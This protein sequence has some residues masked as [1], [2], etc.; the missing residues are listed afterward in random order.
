MSASGLLT[1]GLGFGL[2]PGYILTRGL[3]PRPQPIILQ[4]FSNTR[5]IG[6]LTLLNPGTPPVGVAPL[7]YRTYIAGVDRSQY[8]RVGRS[9]GPG[10]AINLTTS[11]S[12]TCTFTVNGWS[13][14]TIPASVPVNSQYIPARRDAVQVRRATDGLLMF[15]GFVDTLATTRILGSPQSLQTVVTCVDIGSWLDRRFVAFSG[16]IFWINA[17]ADSLINYIVNTFLQNTGIT[18]VYSSNVNVALGDQLFNYITARE[19]L[20]RIAQQTNTNLTIDIAGNL[21]FV[22]DVSGYMTA[23]ENIT[24]TTANV[25]ALTIGETGMRFAN[26]WYAKSNQALGNAVQVDTYT[27]TQAGWTG[28]LLT[29]AGPPE[30]QVPN[31]SINGVDQIVI[32]LFPPAVQPN[33]T[34]WTFAYIGISVVYNWRLPPLQIGDVIEI[35][36][37]G[38]LLEVGMAE[39][40]ASIAAVGLFEDAV[41]AGAITD[42]DTLQAIAEAALARGKEIPITLTIKTRTDGYQPGQSINVLRSDP[43]INDD[44]LVTSVNSVEINQDYFEHTV[45]CSNKPAQLATD[46]TKWAADLVK[47]LR[48]TTYAIQERITFNLAVSTPPLTNPGF[49]AGVKPMIKQA[50]KNGTAGWVTLIFNSLDQLGAVTTND[51]VIDILKNGTSIFGTV[52][53]TLPA[54]QSQTKFS[55]FASD[56]LLIQKGDVFTCNVITGD[57]A[58]LDGVMELVTLG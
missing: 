57:T 6:S 47:N 17:P 23:P 38:P 25:M 45:K 37:P 20:N 31:V 26:R 49:D 3:A 51:I 33:D 21:R 56:P 53:L 35:T 55:V 15:N 34:S 41:E 19:A 11:A 9:S 40:A 24:D 8:V 32:P 29:Q 43:T 54:G 7:R 18:F 27:Q 48:M 42:K 4:A 52:L 14:D 58:A 46:P 16:G 50:Q 36:Y 5:S 13:H 2:D 12:G 30:G 22:D 1:G 10:I 39:D 28:F 44:F